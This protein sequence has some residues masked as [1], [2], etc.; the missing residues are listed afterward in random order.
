MRNMEFQTIDLDLKSNPEENEKYVAKTSEEKKEL[1]SEIADG[2]N[3]EK[4]IDM[5]GM[6]SMGKAGLQ[7]HHM[8]Q[9]MASLAG[10][11]EAA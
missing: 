7:A 4:Y 3:T 2:I 6:K 9:F 10:K 5:E 1:M 11:R 8:K